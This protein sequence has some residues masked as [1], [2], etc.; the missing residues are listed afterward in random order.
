MSIKPAPSCTYTPGDETCFRTDCQIKCMRNYQDQ[1]DCD[2]PLVTQTVK[3][4]PQQVHWL[5]AHLGFR[6]HLAR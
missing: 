2:I 4:R 1:L 5:K 6:K 3:P